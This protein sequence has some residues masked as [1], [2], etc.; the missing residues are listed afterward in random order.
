MLLG[1]RFSFFNGLFDTAHH[2]KRLLRNVV[3]L[4]VDNALETS[5]GPS[6]KQTY[7]A[8]L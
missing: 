7:L 2:V 5:N 1:Y 8:I 3:V 6:T 4:S